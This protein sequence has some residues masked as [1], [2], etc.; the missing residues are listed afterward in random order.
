MT[1]RKKQ[2]EMRDKIISS[3]DSKTSVDER[4]C[5]V[6]YRMAQLRISCASL[7]AD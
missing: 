2:T 6:R 4:V 1:V 3:T 5:K 7:L